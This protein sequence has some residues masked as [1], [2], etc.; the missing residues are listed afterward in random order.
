MERPLINI[1]EDLELSIEWFNDP[2]KLTLFYKKG[3]LEYL[4][5]WGPDL[6]LEME[7]GSICSNKDLDFLFEWLY[8]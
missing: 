2:K 6:D 7:D 3:L 1:S 5:S 4:K 8:E